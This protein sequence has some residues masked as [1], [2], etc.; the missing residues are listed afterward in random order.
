MYTVR[1]KS[2]MQLKPKMNTLI[3]VLLFSFYSVEVH[4]EQKIRYI[5]AE[6]ILWD[7]APSGRNLVS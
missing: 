1:C 3:A 2:F 7:Y 6:E 4:S 5:A